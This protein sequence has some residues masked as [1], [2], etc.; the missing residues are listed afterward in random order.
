MDSD[1]KSADH[2][3]PGDQKDSDG[4]SDVAPKSADHLSP[5]ELIDSDGE[6]D[7]EPKSAAHLLPGDQKDSDGESD[8]AP[9]SADH[10]SPVELIDSDGES[11]VAPKSADHL[12]PVELIDSDGEHDMVPKSAAHLLP[13]DQKDSDGEQD[14]EPKSADHLL[15]GDQK[16]SDGESDVAPKSADHLSPV[17]LIDS[18]GE[19]DMVPK[20][21]DHLLPGDQKDSDGEHEMAP[22]SAG[23]LSPVEL[24]DSDGEHDMEQKSAAHLQPGDQKDSDGES[25]V[26]PKSVD[27]LSPVELTDSDGER[28]VEPKSADQQQ[29]QKK[30]DPFGVH[31]YTETGLVILVQHLRKGPVTL[32]LDATGGVVSRIPSQAKRVFYYSINLPG[33]GKDKPPLPV[34]EMITNDHT[35]PNVSFWLHQTVTKIRKLTLYNIHQVE[36]DYSWAL[37]QSVLLSFNKQDINTYLMESYNVVK[38]N[39]TMTEFRR[40]TVLHLCSAH[41]IKAVQGAIGRKT[42]DKGL[43]EFA[44]HCVAQ[45]MNTTSLQR[46]L[47][48]FKCMCYVFYTK[49]NTQC[50]NQ[51]LQT[52]QDHIRGIIIPEDTLDEK[53]AVDDYIPPEAKTILARSP[54]TKEFGSVLEA[55]M[56][57]EDPE[58]ENQM[59]NNKYH[60][61]EILDILMKDYMPIFPLWSGLM[62]GDLKR[63][64]DRESI[65]D[66]SYVQKTHD[67]NC[68]AENW[69]CIVKD[70]ILLKKLHHRPA[71]FIQKMYASLQG[72]Y[73]EHILQHDLPDRMLQ[74]RF[75]VKQHSLEDFEE[76]WSKKS[77]RDRKEKKTKYFHTPEVMPCPKKTASKASV[78]Q[79]KSKIKEKDSVQVVS[80]SSQTSKASVRQPKSKIKEKD[81]VQV[82]SD[83]S[84]TSKASVRQPKSKIKEKDSVQVVSDSSQASN[85]S[86]RQPKSR[87]KEKDS[88]QVVSDSSQASKASVRQPK[89]KIK[90]KDSVQVVSTSSQ[91]SKASVRQPKSKIKEKDSVQVVSDSSQTS[92]ASVR[93]P[94]SKIK[95]KDSVQVVS[96]SSQASKASVRQPK[97]KIK[98][99]DSVQVVSDSS[100]ASKTSVRH[101]KSTM[102][103]KD[104]EDTTHVCNEDIVQAFWN[105]KDCEVVVVSQLTRK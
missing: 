67:T 55:V 10:L 79:P 9:K 98:E 74:K 84:Q 21:A 96:D 23:H 18:D 48:I 11:D 36:T 15:P 71:T 83:S 31:L 87:M 58:L 93:Q 38:G 14:M 19:H 66:D 62:L 13:G 65:R 72:R 100:Q 69:F 49:S 89:S 85:D 2:L 47:D 51:S 43:K 99:K 44:T 101:P 95:E 61:P 54:F 77:M 24:I 92:K 6:Q 73:R 35:I 59:D 94:K 33:H 76:K 34:S 91:T 8:V 46:A 16:D 68:H 60:C 53:Q 86:V 27:H 20:S 45:L 82:V 12:S 75:N 63:F 50:V 5:V 25:D 70:K 90:E 17:E 39:N 29:N 102:K 30:V 32:H 103:E 88:V 26:A 3:Q 104:T 80:D 57:I 56:A 22:K 37:I 41:I 28:D 40:L 97:S 78:R 81:S 64:K 52:L 105:S 7:M 42:T 1:G 4:E